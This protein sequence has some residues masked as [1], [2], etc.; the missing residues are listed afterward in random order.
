M[1]LS[2]I[3]FSASSQTGD[4]TAQV[5]HADGQRAPRV[6]QRGEGLREGVDARVGESAA[7][8][9]ERVDGVGEAREELA[10]EDLQ[11]RVADGVSC[12]GGEV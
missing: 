4:T 11:A 2:V 5:Q 7:G 12:V 10:R 8:E 9:I 6:V 1:L 3:S